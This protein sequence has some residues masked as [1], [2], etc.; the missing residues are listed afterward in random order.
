MDWHL[1]PHWNAVLT[2]KRH[3]RRRTP[4]SHPPHAPNLRCVTEVHSLRRRAAA[5]LRMSQ[6]PLTTDRQPRQPAPPAWLGFE[7]PPTR[8]VLFPCGAEPPSMCAAP[9]L[10]VPSQWCRHQCGV[11]RKLCPTLQWQ[12]LGHDFQP[13]RV[14]NV[15]CQ[16]IQVSNEDIRRDPRHCLTADPCSHALQS[17]TPP[18]T[19]TVAEM[20]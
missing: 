4:T 1:H 14:L 12:T 7:G 13:P 11:H 20:R 19:P 8:D 18:N 2:R 15:R 17:R 5:T 6:S 9:G 10:A 16:E 3:V